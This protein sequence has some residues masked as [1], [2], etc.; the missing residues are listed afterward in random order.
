MKDENEP[1]EPALK[2]AFGRN[3]KSF[4]R[5]LN[6]DRILEAERALKDM[7]GRDRLD[8]LT[9]LDVGSDSGLSSLAARRLGAKVRSFDADPQS[10]ACTEELKHRLF[11]DDPDWK[12]EQGSVLDPEFLKQLGT[13]DVVYSWG[14]LHHTGD[15]WR[16]LESVIGN[17][18]PHGLL[19]LAIYNEQGRATRIWKIVKRTY[20]TLPPGLRHLF[21]LSIIAFLETG[22]LLYSV[23]TLRPWRYVRMWT[24]YHKS[25]G[26]N[27]LHDWWDWI[28][29]WPFE[30]A[31]PEQIFN[32]YR[33]RGFDLL[34]LRTCAGA[35]GNNEFVFR[36]S[37]S[38]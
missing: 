29:G 19:Q 33:A 37:R 4:L 1:R 30:V 6:E 22:S 7:L 27:R 20:N 26:M 10:V 36:R 23:L 35:H 5:S 31:L 11:P 12:V 14:V 16:A 18:A 8:G 28:G 2:F 13:F 34:R 38:S 32:F 17:V 21:A 9:F 24:Q 3:W 15:M 25:R